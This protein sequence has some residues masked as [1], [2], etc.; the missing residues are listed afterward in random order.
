[1]EAPGFLSNTKDSQY[2]FLKLFFELCHQLFPF[3]GEGVEFGA[4]G[5]EESGL[6]LGF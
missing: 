2:Q 5:F 1:M 6:A 4:E 3:D